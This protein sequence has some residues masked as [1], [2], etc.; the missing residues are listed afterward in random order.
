MFKNK[1]D[2][3]EYN[4]GKRYCEKHNIILPYR[5]GM[6]DKP[7]KWYWIPQDKLPYSLIYHIYYPSMDRQEHVVYMTIGKGLKCLME[8]TDLS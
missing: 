8:I 5:D 2:E 6:W 3:E 7:G 4:L 1:T